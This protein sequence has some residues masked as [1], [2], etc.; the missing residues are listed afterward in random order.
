VVQLSKGILA[1]NGNTAILTKV[2]LPLQ[3]FS[4]PIRKQNTPLLLTPL[5]VF[6]LVAD[7]H[8]DR[9]TSV[10]NY[11]AFFFTY[12]MELFRQLHNEDEPTKHLLPKS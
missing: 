5:I 12:N 2:Y 7:T 8:T 6:I 11:E 4:A 9:K 1:S 10:S 3:S